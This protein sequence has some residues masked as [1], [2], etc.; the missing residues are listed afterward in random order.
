M[1]LADEPVRESRMLCEPT[2]VTSA[3][4]KVRKT[5]TVMPAIRNWNL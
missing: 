3:E 1:L 4:T 2:A 5:R